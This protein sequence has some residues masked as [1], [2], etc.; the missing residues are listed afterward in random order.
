MRNRIIRRTGGKGG[1]LRLALLSSAPVIAGVVLALVPPPARA[2]PAF[3]DQT[4]QPC[5]ACH[6]GGF[7]P[8]LTPFGREF[9]LGGYTLR[10]KASIPLAAMAVASFTHTNKDQNPPP[11][12][13]AANNNFALDQASLFLAGGIGQHF[14]GFA[15][16]T[17]DGVARQF[18]WD[19]LD[20]RLVNTGQ[21]MGKDLTYG[22]SINN[23]P[24]VEDA[25]NTTPAWGFPYTSST[26]AATP[27]ASPLID[28]ALA[29]NVLGVVAYG[30]LDHHVYLAAGAYTS[31]AAGTLTWLGVD[32][33]S[34]GDI[35]GLAPYGR[36]AYQLD[37]AGGTAEFGAYA[38]KAEINPG[39]QSVIG[40]TDH[41]A[42]L[43]LDASWQKALSSG[44]TLSLN[45]R[46]THE[47][48]NLLASCALGLIGNG[49]T[50]VC[51]KTTLSEWRGAASYSWRGRIGVT[52]GGFVT[53]GSGNANLY[54]P[55]DVPD[56]NGVIG[57]VDYTPWGSGNSLL[58]PLVNL[59]VG[60]QYTAYGKFNGARFNY[61]G[62]GAN[63]SDNNTLRV[64]TWVAF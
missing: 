56:S 52:L 4:G 48:S 33:T 20:V 3:T 60:V 31:P 7:G 37:A 10:T 11:Q 30:W 24:T 44:D 16:A 25:W 46:Y 1:G 39:R 47:E 57:Q 21:I 59:R 9:K 61:D 34:P 5:A 50:P 49:T 26:L 38:L 15:Q 2:V 28:G 45:M 12:Y 40:Y 32:P 55:T 53:N 35:H 23:A 36:I 8:E 42:D 17:Y 54:A 51:A 58:G 64:F 18:H 6:V 29:Q 13:F 63:A 19:N 41:Y 14:G 27:G 62:N 43:G 22:I